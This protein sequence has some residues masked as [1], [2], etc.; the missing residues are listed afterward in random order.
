MEQYRCFLPGE[1][2]ITMF[3]MSVYWLWNIC[4]GSVLAT[5]GTYWIFDTDSKHEPQEDKAAADVTSYWEQ[6]KTL[7]TEYSSWYL[8]L[9]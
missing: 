7:K 2:S 1:Y 3:I 8:D 6:R 4:D 9:S 5:V